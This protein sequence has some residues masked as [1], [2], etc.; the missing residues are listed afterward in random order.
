MFSV[1]CFHKLSYGRLSTFLCVFLE[2]SLFNDNNN[3]KVICRD[4]IEKYAWL[5]DQVMRTAS[6]EFV[7]RPLANAEVRPK[8][9]EL[10]K[11]I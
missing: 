3:D 6:T 5:N 7:G 2:C 1:V 11:C 10:K 8:Y 9:S 4:D